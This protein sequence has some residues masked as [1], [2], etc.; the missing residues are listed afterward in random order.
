MDVVQ[1]FGEEWHKM[2]EESWRDPKTLS[3]IKGGGGKP[4]YSLS[5]ISGVKE[6]YR[7]IPGAINGI[8][9]LVFALNTS[10]TVT[11]MGCCVPGSVLYPWGICCYMCCIQDA[12]VGTSTSC[13][14]SAVCAIPGFSVGTAST[15]YVALGA[16]N[17]CGATLWRRIA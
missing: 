17:G 12:N 16:I 15:L 4:R 3:L 2:K 6:S 11:D 1:P 10:S 14:G 7:A 5:E 13:T 8:G 9:Q